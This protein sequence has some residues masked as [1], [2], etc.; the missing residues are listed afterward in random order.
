MP[1]PNAVVPSETN[2]ASG[3]A[4]SDAG[5]VAEVAAEIGALSSAPGLLPESATMSLPTV[6]SSP[7]ASSA[8]TEADAAGSDALNI[9]WDG[10][11]PA[12]PQADQPAP[13]VPVA[14]DPSS[15]PVAAEPAAMP[16][17]AQ[18]QSAPVIV[19]PAHP[20]V[21]NPPPASVESPASIDASGLDITTPP[22]DSETPPVDAESRLAS[23]PPD[24]AAAMRASAGSTEAFANASQ[25]TS[26][27][28]IASPP[29]GD[30]S[31]LEAASELASTDTAQ[32]APATQSADAANFAA[33]KLFAQPRPT[34][35]A[36]NQDVEAAGVQA[37]SIT[38]DRTAILVQ[39]AP[40]IQRITSAI[41][42]M[43]PSTGGPGA[44]AVVTL[45]VS[46]GGAGVWLRRAGRRRAGRL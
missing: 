16:I 1:D 5:D 11:A 40:Q 20:I 38:P 8:P 30:A 27:Q 19:P 32:A 6:E 33:G 34:P 21:T 36:A 10:A 42:G 22:V 35:H 23:A 14:D 41:G 29:S 17:V 3:T 7:I 43:I 2:V 31:T 46:I 13:E 9:V 4:E 44:L 28:S 26:S 25:G 39:V 24:R 37:V 45:L 18:P 15:L 12:P